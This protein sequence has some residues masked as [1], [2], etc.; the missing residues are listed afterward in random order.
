MN[1]KGNAV[2]EAT[3][4]LPLFVFCILAVYSMI[5]C[6]M[7]ELEVYEAC[8][9][10]A[11]YIAEYGYISEAGT[12]ALPLIVFDDY[13]NNAPLVERYI[14]GGSKGVSFMGSFCKDGYVKLVATYELKI[15]VPF[16]SKL[17]KTKVIS[18]SQRIYKG[19]ENSEE[20]ENDEYVFVADS[21][22]V[23]HTERTCFCLT[24]DALLV[25]ISA[26]KQRGLSG[27]SLCGAKCGERV[28]VTEQ[29]ERYHS[30]KACSSLKRTVYRV[31]RKDLGDMSICHWC[32]E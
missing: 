17:S 31:K 16:F 29:G 32:A 30:T 2:V 28:Y 3:L 18:L 6:K 8:A 7:A 25:D 26:A 21:G 4:T 22:G 15:S 5:R 1:N 11:E 9:E 12:E 10:T 20:Y 13:I 19:L 24:R 27:C 23:Y 14:R